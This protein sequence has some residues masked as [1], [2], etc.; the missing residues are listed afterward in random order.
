MT[1]LINGIPATPEEE[2]QIEREAYFRQQNIKS[3]Y[4]QLY[5]FGL[6]TDQVRSKLQKMSEFFGNIGSVGDLS[7]E[8]MGAIEQLLKYLKNINYKF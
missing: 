5:E 4:V 1:T 2:K 6:K 7:G 8:Q 3:L